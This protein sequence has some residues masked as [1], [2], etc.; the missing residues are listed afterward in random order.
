MRNL[1]R[2]WDLDENF[3]GGNRHAKSNILHRLHCGWVSS[4]LT[5]RALDRQSRFKPAN[6]SSVQTYLQTKHPVRALGAPARC[7][8]AG[9]EGIFISLAVFNYRAQILRLD[10]RA[11]GDVQ[12]RR[13]GNSRNWA[14]V[15][16]LNCS[17]VQPP[18]QAWVIYFDSLCLQTFSFDKLTHPPLCIYQSDLAALC[19]TCGENLA[20]R[21]D[22]ERREGLLLRNPSF[23]GWDVREMTQ[24]PAPESIYRVDTNQF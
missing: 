5:F 23:S 21:K 2:A 24:P 12:K 19:H 3:G 6:C 22:S 8:L 16:T 17:I 7:C 13:K 4:H 18:N 1:L 9:S 10:S 20:G 14:E 11:R 15:S